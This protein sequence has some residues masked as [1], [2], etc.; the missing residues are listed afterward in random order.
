MSRKLSLI[1]TLFCLLIAAAAAQDSENL[2]EF[3]I[4]WTDDVFVLVNSS[5]A[6]VDVSNLRLEG[7]QGGINTD[8]WRL[9]DNATLAELAPGDCLL[10]YVG[11]EAPPLPDDA[12]CDRVIGR[13]EIEDEADII[14]NVEGGGFTSY[15]GEV[16]DTQC[17]MIEPSCTILVPVSGAA[18]D[19]AE[20]DEPQTVEIRA[21]WTPDILVVINTSSSGADLRQMTL[22]SAL[23][24]ISPENWDL[25][26]RRDTG[27]SYTLR[28]VRPGGCLIAYLG[29][30]QPDIPD[31]VTCDRVIG[32]FVIDSYDNVVWE[33]TQGGFTPVVDG[34][35]DE[36]C[37]IQRSSCDITVPDAD[38]LLLTGQAA[39][40]TATSETTIRA[41]WN[42]EIFVVINNSDLD[43]DVTD[44]TFQSALG[45]IRPDDWTLGSDATGIPYTL[46]AMRPGDCLLAYFGGERPD[47]PDTVT[48]SQVIGEYGA[49]TPN[50]LVWSV[51]QGGFTPLVEAVPGEDCSIQRSSCDFDVPVS[52]VSVDAG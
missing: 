18:G 48:C 34:V 49:T 4:V 11:E 46:T 39:D 15:I 51:M 2:V 30:E 26:I 13:Y 16:E 10:A 9:E 42:A 37:S 22:E 20:I 41:I 19:A 28:N 43:A 17:R 27:A 32:R 8:D 44:L 33:V 7:T 40:E 5:D 31:T 36:P 45:S 38:F 52:E 23:G 50:A 21:I 24:E 12:A 25:G 35:A 1:I 47:I 6:T 3:Q 29:A 14:W